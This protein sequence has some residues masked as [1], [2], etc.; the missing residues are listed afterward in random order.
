M[1]D[2]TKG[3]YGYRTFNKDVLTDLKS[4]GYVPRK[5]GGHRCP[6]TLFH[7]SKQKRMDMH[8]GERDFIFMAS[9]FPNTDHA[10]IFKKDGKAT[11]FLSCPYQDINDV[12]Q[13]K[14][15]EDF[16]KKYGFKMTVSEKSVYGFGSIQIEVTLI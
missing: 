2:T 16:C 9:V 5:P 8:G 1:T 10:M 15:Q 6:C 3:Y 14:L 11:M 7:P 13:K 4:R 12:K